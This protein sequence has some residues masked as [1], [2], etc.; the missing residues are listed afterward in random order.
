MLEASKGEAEASGGGEKPLF[1]PSK[2]LL[3]QQ[4]RLLDKRNSCP[5]N[6]LDSIGEKYDRSKLYIRQDTTSWFDSINSIQYNSPI[7]KFIF[8]YLGAFIWPK[9]PS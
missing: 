6:N 8:N 9:N 4:W 5:A 3:N 2:I 7:V 1:S